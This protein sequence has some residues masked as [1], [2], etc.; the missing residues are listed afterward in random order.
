[1]SHIVE[2]L[3]ARRLLTLIVFNGPTFKDGILREEGGDWTDT[4]TFER[5]GPVL[6][7]S[8][9]IDYDPGNGIVPVYT[10]TSFDFDLARVKRIELDLG[11]GDDT[12]ILGSVDVP[13][14]VNG[15]AGSD[16]LS[17]GRGDDTLN[18]G[19]D[20]DV[21]WGGR[22]DDL[23][24]GDA[25]NDRLFG[26]FGVDTLRGGAGDDRLATGSAGH[27][28]DGDAGRDT[29]LLYWR[30][31]NTRSLE[32]L[33]TVLQFELVALPLLPTDAAVRA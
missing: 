27:V 24:Q 10:T 22:G 31:G 8:H 2:S 4:V 19:D 20:L 16:S 12:V 11:G 29:G 26:A 33:P 18:G 1:M 13:A 30:P 32:R 6:R 17:G 5:S 28:L 14:L 21:L 7:V 25:G 3:E 23:L 9:T 15:G